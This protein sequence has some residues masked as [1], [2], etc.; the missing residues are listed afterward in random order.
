MTATA[1]LTERYIAATV[2]S[3]TPTAQDDEIGRAH[4]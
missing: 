4:V 1:T 2:K 3:I